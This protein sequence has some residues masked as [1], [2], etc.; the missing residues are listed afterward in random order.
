MG[1]YHAYGIHPDRLFGVGAL[2]HRGLS[3]LHRGLVRGSFPAPHHHDP[4]ETL[5]NFLIWVM[6]VFPSPDTA[7][8]RLR[9][10]RF[11]RAG[12]AAALSTPPDVAASLLPVVAAPVRAWTKVPTGS[13]APFCSL[14]LSGLDSVEPPQVDWRIF[15]VLGFRRRESHGRELL[16]GRGRGTVESGMVSEIVVLAWTTQPIRSGSGGVSDVFHI[17]G[18]TP[19]LV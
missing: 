2:A 4:N 3:P 5:P 18:P 1:G 9:D 16:V 15:V 12:G 17:P 19:N 7:G 14:T 8:E 11:L 13:R 10:Q 6:V